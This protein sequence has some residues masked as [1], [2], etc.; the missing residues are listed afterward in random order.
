MLKSNDRLTIS[1]VIYP[2]EICGQNDNPYTKPTK[3][4]EV[5][6]LILTN[7]RN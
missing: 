2:T 6:I 5:R 7:Q 4:I 1:I 3:L